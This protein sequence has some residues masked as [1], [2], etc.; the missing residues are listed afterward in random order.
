MKYLK[1]S[2]LS[3]IAVTGVLFGVSNQQQATVHFFWFASRSYHLYLILFASFFA[4]TLTA[5]L[6]GIFSGSDQKESERR[7]EKHA[8]D[9]AHLIKKA[10]SA[11]PQTSTPPDTSGQGF[12]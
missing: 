7:L 11:K 6:Y 1:F 3:A 4:G 2:I 8:E 12:F 10:Q 5:I 9:L